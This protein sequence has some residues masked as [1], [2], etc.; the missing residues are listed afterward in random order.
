MQAPVVLLD[1]CTLYPAALRDVLM[2]MALHGLILA[3]WTDAIHDEW[4][5]A[6]L[7]DRPDLSRAQLERTRQLMNLHAEDSLVT[8]HEKRIE[9]L[10]LPDSDDRH[11]LA[12]A[13]EAGADVLL[14]WNL[15]DFPQAT[16]AAHGMTAETPDALLARLC[17]ARRDQLLAVLREARSCLKNPPLTAA[18]YLETLRSQGLKRTCELLE[19]FLS[20]I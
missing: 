7:R 9:K 3:R 20:E 18:A 11:V 14:T 2:R 4:I 1:A 16:L 10:D 6:V 19:A 13:I 8:G 5:E 15:R 12:A 17:E